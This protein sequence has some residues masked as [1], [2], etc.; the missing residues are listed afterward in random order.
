MKN[1]KLGSFLYVALGLIV[2]TV[3]IAIV[4]YFT[5]IGND[6]AAY[7]CLA[8]FAAI[9]GFWHYRGIKKA[10]RTLINKRVG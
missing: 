8:I 2:F 1:K 7:S 3:M 5:K 9:T 4:V 6:P 10:K